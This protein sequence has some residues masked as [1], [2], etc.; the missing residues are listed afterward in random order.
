MLFLRPYGHGSP[1]KI[2][3][4]SSSE[5]DGIG[6]ENCAEFFARQKAVT[7]LSNNPGSFDNDFSETTIKCMIGKTF[8]AK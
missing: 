1:P 3:F 8:E 5:S 4:V 2:F 6:F 7:I